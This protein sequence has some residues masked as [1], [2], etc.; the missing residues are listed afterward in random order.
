MIAVKQY[1]VREVGAMKKWFRWFGKAV[2]EK[3]SRY[4]NAVSVEYEYGKDHV[5]RDVWMKARLMRPPKAMLEREK[6]LAV[7]CEDGRCILYPK[8]H[9]RSLEMIPQTEKSTKAKHY[10]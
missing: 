8:K 3:W 10:A 5:H 2:Q 1:L 7:R 6:W 4:G 9:V